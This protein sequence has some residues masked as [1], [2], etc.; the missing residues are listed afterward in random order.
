MPTVIDNEGFRNLLRSYPGDA[1]E[2][3]YEVLGKSLLRYAFLLTRD[4]EAA[5]D[6]VQD[7]FLYI[8]A[9]SKTLSEHHELPFE[10]YVIR[11]VRFKSISFLRR[12][13]HL[14]I[15][16]LIFPED[17]TGLPPENPVETTIIRRELWQ[18]LRTI[19][20]SFP[21]AERECLLLRIDQEMSLDDIAAKLNVTRKA[22]ERSIYSGK[23]R[24]REFADRLS[25]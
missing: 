13:R 4:Q 19:I 3:L 12:V 17:R 20:A 14:D 18:E 1:V 16:E 24:L 21:R 2:L 23:N 9:N 15:D 22:V 6:V 10:R 8:H 11:I 5:N 7:T 25:E